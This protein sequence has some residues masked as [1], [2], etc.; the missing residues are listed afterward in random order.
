VE[1]GCG[2]E[3]MMWVRDG[4]RVEGVGLGTDGFLEFVPERHYSWK[5]KN[6][7]TV[8]KTNKRVLSL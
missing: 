2:S 1:A 6:N 8:F 3:V 5:A 4:R 7:L